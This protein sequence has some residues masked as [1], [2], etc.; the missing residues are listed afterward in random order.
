MIKHLRA[1][2]E[3][4]LAAAEPWSAALPAATLGEFALQ[5][6][7]PQ[8]AETY[9]REALTYS[10]AFDRRQAAMLASLLVEALSR[11]RDKALDLADAAL[12]A[13]ARWD[14]ISEPDTLHNTFNAARAYI[15]LDRHAEAAALF[16]QAMPRVSVPY[17]PAGVAMTR[18][19]YGRSLRAIGRH[20]EA[21]EQFLE[22]ARIVGDD[23]AQV[24]AQANLASAAA[25][26]LQRSGQRDAALPAFRRAA[27]L[28][29]QLGY[30][31]GRV[32]CLRSAA[33]I[34]FSGDLDA[35]AEAVG[36][37]TMRAVLAEL[38]QLTAADASAELATE[39]D[40]T[41]KQLEGMLQDLANGG[42]PEP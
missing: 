41:R 37:A 40:H 15:Q 38:E 20:E 10:V 9:A 39:L 33:W 35:G 17:D 2:R 5:D 22:A 36:V 21:A 11:Q 29:G 14:G 34:E 7:D 4:Y 23:P 8:A 28:F 30:V 42:S 25:E 18:E 27:A 3:S 26:S 16:A 31:V 1:A 6:G 32:R 12:S 24:Q 19:Q 13:A